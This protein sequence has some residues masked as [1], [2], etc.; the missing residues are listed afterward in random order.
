MVAIDDIM[1]RSGGKQRTQVLAGPGGEIPELE[2]RCPVEGAEGSWVHAVAGRSAGRRHRLRPRPARIQEAA[3][4]P[5]VPRGPGAGPHLRGARSSGTGRRS[6]LG[7]PVGRPEEAPAGMPRTFVHHEPLPRPGHGHRRPLADPRA[8][9]TRP[10]SCPSRAH[11]PLP[12]LRPVQERRDH[13][14]TAPPRDAQGPG[15]EGG[16]PV[17]RRVA[18]L[19]AD[20]ALGRQHGPAHTLLL[21]V[22][23]RPQRV[24]RSPNPQDLR[25]RPCVQR[26]T[27]QSRSR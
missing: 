15:G 10:S 6:G 20:E 11:L 12:G 4:H 24:C 26:G 23:L 1:P 22:E 8:L 13:A 27:L 25:M 18:S 5:R 17:S 9:P 3:G 16:S 21:G 2:L 19:C 7:G 14:L